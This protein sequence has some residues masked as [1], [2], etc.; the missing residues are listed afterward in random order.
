VNP[1]ELA[2]VGLLFAT[3]ALGLFWP[4]FF[5]GRTLIAADVLAASPFW[6]DEPGAIRN[7]WL[8]DTVEYYY[9]SE[10]LYSEAIRRGEL[11]LTN[12]FVFNG[13]PVPHGVHIWNSVWPVKLACLLLFDPVRSYDL[14]A[15]FHW[16]L[17][18]LAFYALARGLGRAPFPAFASALAY[19]LSARAMLWLHGHYMMATL[20]YT[21]L[22]F[23][24]VHR[25]SMLAAI[26]LAG[27]FFTNPHAGIAAT[28]AAFIYDPRAWKPLVVGVL[29]AGIA[30]VPL[31]FAVHEGIRDPS[32]EARFFYADRW[33]CWLALADLVLPGAF[34]TSLP[35]NEAG[36]YLGLLP[37]AGAVLGFRRERYF[38]AL[39]RGALVAAFLWPVPVLLAPLSFSVPLRWLFL[40]A[41]AACLCLARALEELP[42]RRWLQG[43]ILALVL[44]DLVPRFVAYNA[45]HDPAIL[46][47]R[48][49]V[50]VH[51]RGRVGWMLRDAPDLGRP[52]L[53]PLSLLGVSS[54]QGYDVMVPRAHVEA[55]SGVVDVSGGRTL[56]I[57]D[58]DS[59]KLE[60]LGMR[61]LVTDRPM[62]LKRF[63]LV[64]SSGS[65]FV[66]ENP[67][68]PDVAPRTASP[69]P[70][71]AGLAVTLAGCAL[72]VAWALLDRSRP[73]GYS[74]PR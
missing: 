34:R 33:R 64:G 32:A 10:K 16:W 2:R 4:V 54:V 66:Y 41:L 17:A 40:F 14:F 73:A 36:C 71:R 74:E 52:V 27:L 37:L 7:R 35:P 56:W 9:P 26:P 63:R 62:E 23:L 20:A 61:T 42:P 45:T 24:G 25:R 13:A 44:L 15:I 31:A 38:G 43:A 19:V 39:A 3:L 53:A 28:A 22:V 11:P 8:S 58:P 48:P 21:P 51:L 68:A 69:G 57:R 46:R 18:G 60:A 70:L 59:P 1:R 30:L 65:L 47:E 55:L 6:R 49:P 5:R 29:M 72:A 67:A 12:P 50:A